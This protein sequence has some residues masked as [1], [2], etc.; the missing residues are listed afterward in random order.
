MDVETVKLITEM[1][2]DI[3]EI[4]KDQNEMKQDIKDLK[5]LY[6]S[7]DRFNNLEER[8]VKI[9]SNLSKI[10]WI[11]LSAVASAILLLVLK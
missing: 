8:V 7:L 1:Q 4:C 10:T 6:P 2:K 11:V 9:E 5:D 3:K